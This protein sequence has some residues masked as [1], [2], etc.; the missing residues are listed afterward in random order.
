MR[1]CYSYA[2]ALTAKDFAPRGHEVHHSGEFVA[3]A[4]FARGLSMR[5]YNRRKTRRA[6]SRYVRGSWQPLERLP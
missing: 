2:V 1:C 5:E 6:P 3:T 4:V